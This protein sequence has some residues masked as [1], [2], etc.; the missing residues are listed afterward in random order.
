MTALMTVGG[1]L[2][3]WITRAGQAWGPNDV[4]N[5]GASWESMYGTSQTD[6]TNMTGSRDYWQHTVAHNDAAVWDNRYNA[7]YSA[8]DAAGYA[9][10][11]VAESPRALSNYT[12]TATIPAHNGT[13]QACTLSGAGAGGVLVNNGGSLTAVRPGYWSIFMQAGGYNNVSAR[14]FTEGVQRASQGGTPNAPDYLDGIGAHWVGFINA[15]GS[16][17]FQGRSQQASW[18][19]TIT[20]TFIPTPGYQQ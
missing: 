15:S 8:G 5:N 19:G 18:G 6:L 12:F 7:G 11:D 14:I 3:T 1:Y 16:I 17:T 4:W 20:V 10:A 9:R 13:F 2:T